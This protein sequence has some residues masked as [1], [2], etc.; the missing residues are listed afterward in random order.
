MEDNK[1]RSLRY[2][3]NFDMLIYGHIQMFR[4]IGMFDKSIYRKFDISICIESFDTYDVVVI[5]VTLLHVQNI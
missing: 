4:F 5:V 2:I 3:G 1:T